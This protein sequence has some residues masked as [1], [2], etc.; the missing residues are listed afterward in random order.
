MPEIPTSLHVHT[1]SPA[2][3]ARSAAR[4]F[5]AT[6]TSPVQSGSDCSPSSA[7]AGSDPLS[8]A[9]ANTNA[10]SVRQNCFI[11]LFISA[12]HFIPRD[13]RIFL[14]VTCSYYTTLAVF[15]KYNKGGPLRIL[16][17]RYF[18]SVWATAF[19]QPL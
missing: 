15:S 17:R 5:P 3:Q 11:V 9:A 14:T 12:S 10:T 4:F 19:F 2:F 7:S 1:P 8:S 6:A 18:V 16:L 13:L